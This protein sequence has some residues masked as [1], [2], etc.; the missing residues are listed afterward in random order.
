MNIRGR[1]EAGKKKS[2]AAPLELTS[3]F[4]LARPGLLVK[5]QALLPKKNLKG[6]EKEKPPKK[7]G[8]RK[9]KKHR[10]ERKSNKKGNNQKLSR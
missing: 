4:A 2:Y 3:L 8:K 5:V 7:K 9:G 1:L 6:R 10:R